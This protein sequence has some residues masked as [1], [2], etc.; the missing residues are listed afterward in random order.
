MNKRIILIAAITGIML[1]LVSCSCYLPFQLS[2]FRVERG[3]GNVIEE[4][5][6]VSGFSKISLSGA[7]EL[8]IIQGDQESLTIKAEDNLMEMIKTEVKDDTLELSIDQ[9]WFVS[10]M[11]SK[12]IIFTVYVKDL[13]GI[14]ISGAGKVESD[15]I[16]TDQL[17][18]V[19]SGFGDITIDQLTAQTLKLNISGGGNCDLSGEVATQDISIDGAGKFSAEDLKSKEIEIQISGAGDATVWAT[20]TLRVNISGVGHVGYYGDP[21]IHQ[22]ISGAATV[23]QL[24]DK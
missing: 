1:L 14:E 18:I 23:M 11:P 19:S 12:T 9:D 4:T 20:D 8:R 15:A 21:E 17:D 24:G 5:R 6:E 2:S 3:S 7:G 16:Q 13:N 22:S 10:V